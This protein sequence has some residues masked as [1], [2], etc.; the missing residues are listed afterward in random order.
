MSARHPLVILRVVLLSAFVA[1]GLVA[2]PVAPA[3]R[4]EAATSA[5]TAQIADAFTLAKSRIGKTPYKWG[6][7]SL[8]YGADCSGFTYRVFRHQGITLPRTAADQ[9][10]AVRAISRTWRRGGD[11]VFFHGSGG[12]VYHVGI[13]AGDGYIVDASSSRGQVVKRK[14][15]TTSVSYGTLR[16]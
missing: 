6:G 14:I 13:Y 16:P 8:T 15:W 3:P 7:T 4:A 12:Y 5:T 9:R 10:G 1:L 2:V 11:L